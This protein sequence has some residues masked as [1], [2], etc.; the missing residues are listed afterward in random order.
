MQEPILIDKPLGATPLQALGLLRNL[1]KDLVGE[2]L[3]YA[4]RLDPMA[5]GL[6]PVLW[7]E[8][9][10]RQEEFWH[11]DKGY[12][13]TVALGVST[14]SYDVLGI[15]THAA[16]ADIGT[17]HIH[18]ATHALVGKIYLP[19]PV[20]SSYRA[21]GKP[22]FAWAKEGLS[23]DI[24]VPVRRMS[25][26]EVSVRDVSQVPFGEIADV[27]GQRI[28]LVSGDFRQA[29]SSR[30][31][32]MLKESHG[33]ESIMLVRLRIQCASGTYIRSLAHELG[34][35]LGTGGIV[36]DLRRTRVGAWNV[37]DSRTLRLSWPQ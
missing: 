29:E 5:T 31:W 6:L 27:A 33:A 4:G 2:K 16:Q 3:A 37:D 14:D 25:V 19:I 7:G 1:R 32:D 20:F 26:Y 34:R 9:L 22:M 15:P 10:F 36:T 28:A 12:E 11:L 30:A 13:A 21:A 23:Q 18:A 35:R 17:E 24:S 8:L